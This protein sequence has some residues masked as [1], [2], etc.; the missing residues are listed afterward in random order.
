MGM[1]T[2]ERGTG[3]ASG[4]ARTGFVYAAYGT[5]DPMSAREDIER[6]ARELHERLCR[7]LGLDP[8]EVPSRV[9]YASAAVR[10]R[11]GERGESVLS[12]AEA[13]S[14]LASAGAGRVWVSAPYL[15]EGAS[16][17]GL[18]ASLEGAASRFEE[19]RC[20]NPLLATGDD[21]RVLARILD[22]AHP[23]RE[24]RAI[25]LACHGFHGPERRHIEDLAE[26][27]ALRGRCDMVLGALAGEPGLPSVMERMGALDP[28]P[29]RVE[30][31]PVLLTAGVHVM[32]NLAGAHGESWRSWLSAA[33]W[34]VEV[35]T[36][37]LIRLPAVRDLLWDRLVAAERVRADGG[38]AIG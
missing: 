37:G 4:C 8:A 15:A 25:V 33:G 2:G 24:G 12:P 17:R 18:R 6:P 29:E 16:Y 31:A 36:E 21:A 28:A 7:G 30:L 23:R 10:A 9:A 3:S 1:R 5:T 26:R 22:D 35:L 19:L 34:D 20:S 32:E 38:P 11:L 13:L 27:L 14:E